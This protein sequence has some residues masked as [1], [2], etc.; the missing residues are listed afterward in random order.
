MYQCVFVSMDC[1][2]HFQA[3]TLFVNLKGGTHIKQLVL[4]EVEGGGR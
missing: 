4:L 3:T 1:G 2:P